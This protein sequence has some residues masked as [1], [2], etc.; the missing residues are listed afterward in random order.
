MI[1]TPPPSKVDGIEV[2]RELTWER[3]SEMSL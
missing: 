3:I 2:T 1:L